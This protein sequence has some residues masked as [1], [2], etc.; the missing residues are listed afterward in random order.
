[1][2][3]IDMLPRLLARQAVGAWP[4]RNVPGAL[5]GRRLVIPAP[6]RSRPALQVR[7]FA[8]RSEADIKIEELQ[9]L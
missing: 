9:D 3:A 1:M 5:H 8:A 7:G 4:T 2:I 6:L